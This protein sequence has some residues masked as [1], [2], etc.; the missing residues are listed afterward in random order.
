M[1]GRR[2]R[3]GICDEPGP[4]DA[5]CTLDL[6]HRWSHYDATA[7][8]S[9]NDDSPAGWQTDLPHLCTDP[10]CLVELLNTKVSELV[11]EL[12]SERAKNAR[13]S[14]LIG[15]HT[16]VANEQ[17]N[18]PAV[19]ALARVRAVLAHWDNPYWCGHQDMREQIRAALEGGDQQ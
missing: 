6:V 12:A 14:N 8:S 11:V 5:H 2:N 16:K 9:W 4:G 19:Q 15:A 7:D 1:T 3:P 10:A 17:I 13:L 18:Q